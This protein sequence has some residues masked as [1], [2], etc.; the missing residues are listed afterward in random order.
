V[1]RIVVYDPA[2][3]RAGSLE[4]PLHVEAKQAVGN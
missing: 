2:S 4:I 3:A 1:L